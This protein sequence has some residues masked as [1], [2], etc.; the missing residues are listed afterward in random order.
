MDRIK[1]CE[2]YCDW[3]CSRFTCSI[4]SYLSAVIYL[5]FKG[6]C[7]YYCSL[8]NAPTYSSRDTWG[9]WFQELGFTTVSDLL[10]QYFF[11]C[12]KINPLLMALYHEL[13]WMMMILMQ[14]AMHLRGVCSVLKRVAILA[15]TVEQNA[16]T[17]KWEHNRKTS[18]KYM[19]LK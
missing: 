14:I 19:R 12:V 8:T 16:Y 6:Y 1:E 5:K 17:W 7:Y 15:F 10:A 4:T 2:L 11:C 3:S 13:T 9:Q 18:E